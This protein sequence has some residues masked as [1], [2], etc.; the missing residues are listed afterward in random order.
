MSFDVDIALSQGQ[1]RLEAQFSVPGGLTVLFGRSGSGKTTL[2]NAVA[3]LITPERGRIQIGQRVLYDSVRGVALP[4]HKRRLGYIFQDARLFPHLSVQQNLLYAHRFLPRSSRTA[5]PDRI[6]D[7]LGLGA[8]LQRRPAQL[9]GGEKQRV[10]IGRALLAAPELLLADEP[11]TAL[12]EARKLEI[13]PYFERIRDE[14][15]V[16]VLYV[17]HA[18]SEVARLASHVVVLDH[19]RVT[20]VG[21]A[22]G[23]LSD[24]AIVP[25]GVRNVGSVLIAELFLQHSDGLSELRI[26][27]LKLFVPRIDR[28]IGTVMRLRVAA[29]DI[30]L[31]NTRPEGLSALNILP[32]TITAIRA[33]EGPGA[34]VTLE[35][36]GG[37][38]L[39]RVTQRSVAMLDLKV[40]KAIYAIMKSVAIAPQDIGTDGL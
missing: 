36:A 15:K 19:G 17:S 3:G 14:L 18:A 39:A 40:G 31:S 6:V 27:G 32:G 16:P 33:G 11:L 8:L 5:D 20:Q 30:I 4:A 9:S 22:S 10:A 7:L 29:H 35:T 25:T 28:P 24:P 1:F 37:P 23:V 34:L 38:M 2:I 13:L 12:D 21:S 26:N